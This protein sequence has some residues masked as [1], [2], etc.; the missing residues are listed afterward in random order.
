MSRRFDVR[1]DGTTTSAELVDA[2]T[3]RVADQIFHVVQLDAE[4]CLVSREDGTRT[5]VATVGGASAPWLFAAGQA[6]RVEVAD[7]GARG[8]A[9]TSD[10][11]DMTAPMPATVVSIAAPPGTR[12]SAGDAVVVLEA[13]KMELVIRAPRDGQVAAVHCRVGDLVQPGTRLAEL[14][15]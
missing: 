9:A 5:V 1:H 2:D 4:R 7:A 14:G 6:W 11:E 8:P 15:P 12:V 13:M 3:I 10:A